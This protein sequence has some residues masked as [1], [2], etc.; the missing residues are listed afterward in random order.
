MN[1]YKIDKTVKEQF[2]NKPSERAWVRFASRFGMKG[3]FLKYK[4]KNNLKKIQNYLDEINLII[5]FK[6]KKND[7]RND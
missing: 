3:Y 5:D 7:E 2:G 1:F 4:I 6:E